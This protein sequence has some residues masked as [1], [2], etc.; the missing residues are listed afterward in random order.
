M[1]DSTKLQVTTP[2]ECEIAMTRVFDAPRELVF[3][4]LTTPALLQRWLLGPPGWSMPVCEIDLR[5]GGAYRYVWRYDADG[6]EMSMGGI[7]REILRPER[8]VSTERFDQAWYAGDAVGTLLL[9]ESG[10]RTT[11]SNTMRYAS[12]EVRDGVLKSGME[13]GVA[14]SYDR[15]EQVLLEP[16]V[17]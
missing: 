14:A 16:A 17:A 11:M 4:A 6:S 2:G 15:L 10:G 13:R 8:I 12:K 9:L 7:Y 1:S 3:K 5:V